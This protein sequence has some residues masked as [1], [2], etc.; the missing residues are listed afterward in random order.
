MR[1][2]LFYPLALLTAAAMISASLGRETFTQRPGAQAGQAEAG[3]ALRF[4]PDALAAIQAGEEQLV[5]I[6]RDA[7]GRPVG[8]RVASRPGR[9]EPLMHSPGA[10]LP[11]DET[12]LAAL[13]P[14]P[15]I[16]ELDIRPLGVTAAE[17][18][19]VG[20]GGASGF[21]EWAPAQ[22]LPA[23][24]A[25]LRFRLT[26]PPDGALAA[27]GFWPQ[28]SRTDYAFGVEITALRVRRD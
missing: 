3:G 15:W 10:R 16:A 19:F 24:P 6:A 7:A 25:T 27:I 18:L 14:G 1:S 11:L 12:A 5:F 23:E 28:A 9:G 26:A 20:A 2:L 22:A 4:G 13:G 8:A 17:T 21:S